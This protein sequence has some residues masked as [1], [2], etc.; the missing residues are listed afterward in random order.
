[1]V[2]PK[3]RLFVSASLFALWILFLLY[4]VMVT[5]DPVI[6]SRPQILVSNLCVLAKIDERGGQAAPEVLISKVLWSADDEDK[7]LEGQPLTLND[8]VDID[9]SQ[10]WWGAEEYLL[11]LTKR[12][13]GKDV[14]YE[15]T[16][17]PSMPGF[18]PKTVAVELIGTGPNREQV[19]GYMQKALGATAKQA[20][21]LVEAPSTLKRFASAQVA[22]KLRDDLAKLDARVSLPGHE[23]RIYRATD[24]ALRQFH[25]LK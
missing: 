14:V 4:L 16:A 1:M 25:E 7:A 19:M 15:L 20:A 2:F 5:R 21:A 3:A 24:D 22:Q 8:L 11:P 17:I 23:T 10:G 18:Q 9:A 13:D 6:L 12:R